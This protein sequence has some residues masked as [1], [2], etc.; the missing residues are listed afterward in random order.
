MTCDI[1]PYI[2]YILY[3]SKSIYTHKIKAGCSQS[4]EESF[5]NIPETL[6]CSGVT[7]LARA[8]IYIYTDC[9]DQRRKCSIYIYILKFTENYENYEKEWCNFGFILEIS[10]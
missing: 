1:A 4:N 2:V 5:K 8:L 7:A 10:P 3:I 9:V 6:C